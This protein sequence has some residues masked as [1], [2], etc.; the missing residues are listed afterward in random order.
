MT[1]VGEG[2][3]GLHGHTIEIGSLDWKSLILNLW[4]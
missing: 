4:L 3:G 2:E 1:K